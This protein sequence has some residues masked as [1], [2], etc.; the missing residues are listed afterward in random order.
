[1]HPNPSLS[2]ALRPS[3]AGVCLLLL[4]L[5]CAGCGPGMVTGR[6]PPA[7]PA[8]GTISGAVQGPEGTSAV[9]GRSVRAVN[10]VTGDQTSVQTNLAGT[11]TFQLQPGTYRLALDLNPG[12]AL[13]E[14]PEDIEVHSGEIVFDA[15]F[16]LTPAVSRQAPGGLQTR[17]GQRSPQLPAPIA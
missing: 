7:E 6:V 11:F 8:H 14:Q 1:M 15:D 17:P 10:V 16:T 13:V 5:V 9:E 12:E 4:A 2:P 3:G